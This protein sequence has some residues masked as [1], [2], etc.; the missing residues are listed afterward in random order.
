MKVTKVSILIFFRSKKGSLQLFPFYTNVLVVLL[1]VTC[2][3]LDI[4][5]FY[6]IVQH[7]IVR[8]VG[9]Y[10]V[11]FVHLLR[12]S[13][14]FCFFYFIDVMYEIYC[15][16]YVEV[17]LHFWEKSKLSLWINFLVCWWIQFA[18]ILM[19]ILESLFFK[20]VGL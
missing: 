20:D 15:L 6:L 18:L 10:Q 19:R 12:W 5:F 9:F 7:F 17:C 8:D 16:V 3:V 11:T 13:C 1:Y 4:F 2:I 14:G